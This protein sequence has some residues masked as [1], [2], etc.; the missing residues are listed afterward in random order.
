MARRVDRLASRTRFCGGGIRTRGSA[1]ASERTV[2]RRGQVKGA[3]RMRDLDLT[4]WRKGT[5][6]EKNSPNG[7]AP[8]RA[9][10]LVKK[11]YK[12]HEPNRLKALPLLY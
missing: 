7:Q 9:W 10:Y 3:V 4:F 2:W 6:N 12:G 1:I 11:S 8:N 5:R